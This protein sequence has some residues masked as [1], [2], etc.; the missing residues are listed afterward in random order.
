MQTVTQA[1]TP[2]SIAQ[3]IAATVPSEQ[4]PAEPEPE[5]AHVPDLQAENL[6]TYDS[7]RFDVGT[8]EQPLSVSDL[9]GKVETAEQVEATS[10][11]DETHDTIPLASGPEE[12]ISVSDLVGKPKGPE[13]GKLPADASDAAVHA[14]REAARAEQVKLQNLIQARGELPAKAHAAQAEASSCDAELERAAER[15]LDSDEMSVDL[16]LYARHDAAKRLLLTIERRGTQLDKQIERQR[17]AVRE[18]ERFAQETLNEA[19]IESAYALLEPTLDSVAEL[20]RRG[21]SFSR[22]PIRFTTGMLETGGTGSAICELTIRI[23]AVRFLG[24]SAENG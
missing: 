2:I 1:E 20:F 8:E 16:E 19:R 14:A 6:L 21:V 23:P 17:L 22:G 3:L 7:G 9:I 4:A 13:L 18:A 10:D 5:P 12:P 24:G 11:E 15:A